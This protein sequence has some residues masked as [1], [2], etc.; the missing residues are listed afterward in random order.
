MAVIVPPELLVK[1]SVLDVFEVIVPSSPALAFVNSLTVD[2]TQKLVCQI[3]VVSIN[4]VVDPPVAVPN[5]RDA[6][7]SNEIIILFWVDVAFADKD[8]VIN[9]PFAG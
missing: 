3:L 9:P 8:A 4:V 5:P 1:L 7:V 6:E 2:P